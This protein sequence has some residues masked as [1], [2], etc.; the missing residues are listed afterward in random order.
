[1]AA[2]LLE[3][4]LRSNRADIDWIEARMNTSFHEALPDDGPQT[5]ASEDDL[6]KA[7]PDALAWLA[8]QLPSDDRDL[9]R[10][11]PGAR[12]IAAA[13]HALRVNVAQGFQKE[14]G[15]TISV[16]H[17]RSLQSKELRTGRAERQ[18]KPDAASPRSMGC[19]DAAALLEL[20]NAATQWQTVPTAQALEWVQQE[21]AQRAAQ[22]SALK[23]GS[24][25]I[26]GLGRFE[27]RKAADDAVKL[28]FTP[29]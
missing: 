20:A 2:S 24:L 25:E 3:P 6:L 19:L 14:R 10:G 21:F 26:S 11:Q 16:T 15:A 29:G 7:S 27:A 18:P 9:L 4:I 12:D 17:Q 23:N 22:L 8:D 5:V 13:M 1:L 28:R